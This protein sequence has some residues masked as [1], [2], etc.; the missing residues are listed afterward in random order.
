M[1]RV[2][3][4]ADGDLHICRSSAIVAHLDEVLAGAPLLPADSA[5]RARARSIAHIAESELGGGL[6]PFMK[7]AFGRRIDP[8][9]LAEEA[10]RAERGLDAI[11]QL[12]DRQGPEPP[13][14]IPASRMRRS[15]RSSSS[16]T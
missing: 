10:S 1:R 14:L 12:M 15:S 8:I 7:V 16:R 9:I 2:P 13:A 4:L 5:G 6:R 3:V 11:E